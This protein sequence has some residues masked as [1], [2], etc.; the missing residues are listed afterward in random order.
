MSNIFE[1]FERK[2]EE[3]ALL[4]YRLTSLLTLAVVLVIDIV[5]NI[6]LYIF[7]EEFI[8]DKYFYIIIMLIIVIFAFAINILVFQKWKYNNYSYRLADT[9]LMITR[10]IITKKKIVISYRDIANITTKTNPILS[11]Y[12]LEYVIIH[13]I[14]GSDLELNA[15]NKKESEKIRQFLLNKKLLNI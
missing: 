3:N 5:V 4:A 13:R 14:V 6:L 15:I 1:K 11:K 2:M 9:E 7:K 8:K 10:G 12:N